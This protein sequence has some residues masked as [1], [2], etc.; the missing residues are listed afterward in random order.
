MKMEVLNLLLELTTGY[1]NIEI[2]RQCQ[3][4]ESIS[5][6]FYVDLAIRNHRRSYKVLQILKTKQSKIKNKAKQ[7]SKI[8]KLKSIDKSSGQK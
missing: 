1:V 2:Y 3:F 4:G 5:I 6:F 7:N 8:K